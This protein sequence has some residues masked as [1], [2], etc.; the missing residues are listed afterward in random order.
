[1]KNLILNCDFEKAKSSFEWYNLNNKKIAIL[2]KRELRK[3]YLNEEDFSDNE[4]FVSYNED[5]VFFTIEKEQVLKDYVDNINFL[6]RKHP[7][8]KNRFLKSKDFVSWK[9]YM[10]SDKILNIIGDNSISTK[11]MIYIAEEFVE[12]IK[13]YESIISKNIEIDYKDFKI[14]ELF[15]SFDLIIKEKEINKYIKSFFSNK[16]IHLVIENKKIDDEIFEYFLYLKELEDKN[17]I[18]KHDVRE[19]LTKKINTI[20]D[21]KQFLVVVKKFINDL[22]SFEKNELKKKIKEDNIEIVYEK[23]DKI[24]LRIKTFEQMQKYGSLSWC[25]VKN[26]EVFDSYVYPKYGI[27]FQYIL[28]D[29]SKKAHEKESMIGLTIELDKKI[30]AAHFK[31]DSLVDFEYNEFIL[32]V[33]KNININEKEKENEIIKNENISKDNYLKYY[34]AFKYNSVNIKNKLKYEKNIDNNK[35]FES[36]LN[37]KNIKK[38][39]IEEL[40]D[41]LLLKIK[42]LN[43]STK[44][45]L[46]K[47]NILTAKILSEDLRENK[48]ILENFLKK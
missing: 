22:C 10:L 16:T 39:E 1:M 36:I 12:Y 11:L 6:L 30:S 7:T 19:N 8:W 27:N 24:C 14:E 5:K 35:L 45:K 34:F 37:L 41:E 4:I 38:E 28:F 29:F 9:K 47:N 23:M 25:I 21:K 43:E 33:L 32:D 2:H 46:R 13:K 3:Y 40:F 18:L 48:E 20:K 17:K 26:K 31:N 44:Q 15:D 42:D